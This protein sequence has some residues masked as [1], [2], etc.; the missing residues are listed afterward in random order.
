MTN[1]YNEPPSPPGI[2][3][4]LN[5]ETPAAALEAIELARKNAPVEVVLLE[6]ETLHDPNLINKLQSH[7]IAV[8]IHNSAVKALE[9]SA[10]GI[11]MTEPDL[12]TFGEAQKR[13]EDKQM[14]IGAEV[15]SSRHI[16]MVLAEQ[17]ASYISLKATEPELN[18]ELNNEQVHSEPEEQF[19]GD[20]YS[21]D[22]ASYNKPPTIEWWTSLIETPCVAWQLQTAEDLE[23]ALKA[24]ADFVAL[25]PALWQDG[26]DIPG[27]LQ[28]LMKQIDPKG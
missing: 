14:I 22:E 4:C 11:H 26:G 18:P 27:N 8:L 15:T 21:E 2:Y 7:N 24:G 13:L 25:S 10:D 6:S 23:N 20:R 9:L 19:L 16:A 17:G 3:L 5:A 12:E 1:Q 28:K